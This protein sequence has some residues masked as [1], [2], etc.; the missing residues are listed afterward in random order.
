MKIVVYNLG[1]KVNKYEC[2][3]LVDALNEKGYETSTKLEK[4]DYYILN[5]CAVTNE[6]ERKSRQFVGKCTKLNKDA[7]IIVCGCASEAD[8]GQ[9]C[10]KSGVVFVSGVANKAGLADIVDEM[11]KGEQYECPLKVDVLP[12]PSEYERMQKPQI[13]R[14][15]AYVKIQDGCNNFCSYCLIPYLRGRNR[16]R[17]MAEVIEECIAMSKE[18]KE[19]VLTGID[20][21]SYGKDKGSSLAELIEN[22]KDIDCRIRFGSLEVSVVDD[23]LLQATQNLKNFCPQFHLSLQSG[24]DNVLK[25]MNRHYTTA[26]YEQRVELIRKYYPDANITTDLICGFPTETEQ[27]FEDTLQFIKKIGFGQIHVFGYSPRK[28]TVAQKFKQLSGEVLSQRCVKAQEVATELKNNY[29][30]KMINKPLEVLYEE[31]EEGKMAGYSKEYIRVYGDA[32]CGQ[33]KE[34][35]CSQKYAQGL[36][37]K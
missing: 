10:D 13:D 25:K 24:C 5:T 35:I 9:F 7:K 19:I 23:R 3:C 27:D 28:G 34:E 29:L 6:A 8:S 26:Q 4:A 15:R 16:S 30:D 33:I 18:S 32:D 36:L 14:T 37:A 1:C 21:S 17:E 2:D 12:L 11:A 20:M 22:L 31:V